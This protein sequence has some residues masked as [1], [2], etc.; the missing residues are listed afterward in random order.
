MIESAAEDEVSL[1]AFSVED[2]SLPLVAVPEEDESLSLS[3]LSLLLEEL[4]V[5]EAS[6]LEP[7]WVPV[8]T[9]TVPDS[10]TPVEASPP[11]TTVVEVPAL[12]MNELREEPLPM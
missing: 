10:T 4:P 2:A 8:G 9:E 12:T 11:T 7:V 1:A 3:L 5:E 6:E